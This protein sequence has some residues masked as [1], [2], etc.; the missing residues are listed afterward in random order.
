MVETQEKSMVGVTFTISKISSSSITIKTSE[1][2]SVGDID[3]DSEETKFKIAKEDS[4]EL[5]TLTMD[6]GSVYKIYYESYQEDI[7]D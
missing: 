1:A 3:F 5:H 2:M 7:N 4:M 6:A